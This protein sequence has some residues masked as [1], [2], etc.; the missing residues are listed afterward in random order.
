M[1]N[2]VI[3]RA[4]RKTGFTNVSTALIRDSRISYGATGLMID[5]LSNSDSWKLNLENLANRKTD[6][7]TKIMGYVRELQKFGYLIIHRERN[8]HGKFVRTVWTV[9]EEPQPEMPKQQSQVTTE[10]RPQ[11]DFP[12]M[13]N[14]DVD[15]PYLGDQGL[16]NNNVKNNQ[17]EET[18]TTVVQPE[19]VVLKLGARS[20]KYEE[21]FY[22]AMN[23]NSLA[24]NQM[25]ELADELE[26]YLVQGKIS[27]PVGWIFAMAS[28]AQRNEFKKPES[29]PIPSKYSLGFSTKTQEPQQRSPMPANVRAQLQNFIKGGKHENPDSQNPNPT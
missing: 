21:S 28:A 29:V 25:Q 14:P 5:L 22:K 9:F 16:R 1:A 7:H 19:L 12:S 15:S 23:Q 10:A 4:I 8:E 20:R 17:F 27:N 13:E 6:R 3:V 11:V 18:T 2:D 26:R 24:S